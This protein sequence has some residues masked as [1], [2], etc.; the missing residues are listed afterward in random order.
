MPHEPIIVVG[1][2]MLGAALARRLAPH[3][4]VIVLE[5]GASLGGLTSTHDLVTAEGAVVPVDRFYHV[6]LSSDRR[7][8]AWLAELGLAEELDFRPVG[9]TVVAAGVAYPAASLAQMAGL[10]FLSVLDRMR[11]AASIGIGA[12]APPGP[13]FSRVPAQRWLRTVAGSSAAGAF[14]DP[15]LRAK[16]GPYASQVSS[17]FL[18]ATFSR[19]LTAR[20]AG[21]GADLFSV[22]PGGYRRILAEA[23][24]QLEDLGVQVVLNAEVTEVSGRPHGVRVR[25]RNGT[26][27]HELTAAHAVL[28]TPATVTAR[29]LPGLS[30]QSRALLRSIPHLGVINVTALLRRAPDPAYLTYIVD[31]ADITSVIGM[32]TLIPPQLTAGRYLVHLPRY[33]APE[34]PIF[35]DTDEVIEKRF[36]SAL[37]TV[38]PGVGPDDVEAVRVA[39]ARYVMPVP[40]LGAP[41]PPPV[42]LGI[43]NVSYIGSAQLEGGTLNVEA[44]LELAGRLLPDALGTGRGVS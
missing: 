24:R 39:R 37:R 18:H 43:D 25:Y 15:L 13:W 32:H 14:W 34:D 44:T 4:P 11:I 40:L 5:A 1:G 16:L 35:E 12:L 19:L 31:D 7:V 36:L 26:A 27:E 38:Y 29:I 17:N 22:V 9:S 28:T 10:P 2:G 3:R 6:I 8:R 30:E 33:C 23:T 41:A 21:G 20:L 42:D